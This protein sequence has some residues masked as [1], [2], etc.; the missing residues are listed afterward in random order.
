[1]C[2]LFHRRQDTHNLTPHQQQILGL[3]HK[4]K[5][6]IIASAAKNLG[7]VGIDTEDYIRL[8]LDHLLDP[9]TYTLLTNKQAAKDIDKLRADIY[10]WTICHCRLLSDDTV[11]FI[12]KQLKESARDPFGYFYLL[13]KLYKQPVSGCPYC[14]DCGS[15]LHALGHWVDERLQPIV[16]D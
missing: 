12:W 3:I 8:G 2:N 15:L 9:S 11:N 7:P 10:L 1:M 16:K 5:S 14:S 13:I 4:N 6:V